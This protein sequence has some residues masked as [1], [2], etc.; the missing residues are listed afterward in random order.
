[1]WD[2]ES[3]SDLKLLSGHRTGVGS[4]AISPDGTTIA[5][6]SW[7][8]T[9]RVLN[10]KTR[11][12]KILRGGQIPVR[13]VAFSPNGTRVASDSLDC[14]IRIWDVE[15]GNEIYFP[16]ALNRSTVEDGH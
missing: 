1:M 15:S 14:S 3:G 2:A 5:T 6:G 11:S 10:M 4:V 12:E 13:C 8:G 7:D 9:V 16:P